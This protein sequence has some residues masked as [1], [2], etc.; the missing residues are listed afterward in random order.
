MKAK[1]LGLSALCFSL[2]VGSA[3]AATVFR[4]SVAGGADILTTTPPVERGTVTLVRRASDGR[5]TSIPT[6]LVRAVSAVPK[7]G[8]VTKS[9]ITLTNMATGKAATTFV[10]AAK[11]PKTAMPTTLASSKAAATLAAQKAGT[12]IVLGPTGG[13]AT[14][15]RLTGD[16]LVVSARA[17]S[18]T[19]SANPLASSVEAQIFRG[20]LPRA[21][22]RG[23][24]LTVG[25][26]AATAATTPFT[27]IG[28]NGFPIFAN[29]TIPPLATVGPNGFLTTATTTAGT[30]TVLPIARNG[31]PDTSA[32]ASAQTGL[33]PVTAARA[34]TVPAT[35]AG[36]RGGSAGLATAPAAAATTASAPA[37]GSAATA[38]PQ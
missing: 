35:A 10:A 4:V 15:A 1:T 22:P 8:A 29:V 12:A 3:S 24:E 32:A 27:E 18:P 36:P 26:N 23:T 7:S 17:A 21:T 5:L 33:R 34:L 28:P 38:S 2:I 19:L 13:G 11:M 14:A 16:T 20:D 9:G 31:F 6:E 37:A 25:G 30:P